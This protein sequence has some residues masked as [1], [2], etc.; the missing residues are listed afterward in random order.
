M[1]EAWIDMKLG[2]DAQIFDGFA[3][4]M[5][6]SLWRLR[7]GQQD[8]GFD[9]SGLRE[10]IDGLDFKDFVAVLLEFI[11]ILGKGFRIA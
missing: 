3:Y 7:S 6:L 9:V 10:H 4:F 8:D 11:Q 2:I 5:F 1:V